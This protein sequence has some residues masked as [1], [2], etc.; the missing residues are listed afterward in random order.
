MSS[1][2]SRWYH[3]VH[4]L[5]GLTI[6]LG[7]VGWAVVMGAGDKVLAFVDPYSAIWVGGLLIGGLWLSFGPM[8]VLR[9][10]AAL[11]SNRSITERELGVIYLSVFT[12]AYQLAW[13]GGLVGLLINF[14]ITLMHLDDPSYLG[15]G[16]AVSLLPVLYGAFLAEFLFAPLRQVMVHRV[17]QYN[18]DLAV[19]ATSYR[20]VVGIG[21]S[22]AFAVLAMVLI[23]ILSRA[24]P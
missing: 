8:T 6:I 3:I 4:M 18:L 15:Q 24:R 16:M 22:V 20:S 7:V 1:P 5:I 10:V 21:V 23:L 14:F 12:R 2:A 13:A 11:L 19:G 17:I 9:A